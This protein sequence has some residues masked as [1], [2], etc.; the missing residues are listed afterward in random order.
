MVMQQV[1]LHDL[2]S[3]SLREDDKL[4]I[5]SNMPGVPLNENNL[6]WRAA[7]L[8]RAEFGL[9]RGVNIYLDKQI[10]MEAG[11]AGGSSNGAAVL[12]SM[13]KLFGLGCSLEELIKLAAKLGADMP[14]CVLGGTALAT[15]IGEIL[16]PLEN[17]LK[18]EVIL[19][20]P[21]FGVP[22]KEIYGNLRLAEIKE[23]PDNRQM[24]KALAAGE[25]AGVV[26]ALGN[27][28]ETV[29]TR[30]YPEV[31]QIKNELNRMGIPAIM[32]GSGATVFGLIPEGQEDLAERAAIAY[33]KKQGYQVF[34][35]STL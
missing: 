22:T 14:F 24:V 17:N 12:R 25:K 10:P 7:N 4:V 35:T 15:G 1:E 16:T 20:K 3:L 5:S 6:A 28:L 32:S 26:A 30:L 8:I 13:N 9:T 2:V 34:F 33:R 19:V 29:T 11:L 31:G 21:P 18:L 23:R 27:V